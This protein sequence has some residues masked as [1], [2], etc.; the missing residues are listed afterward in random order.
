MSKQT[1]GAIVLAAG[2]GKRMNSKDRN[3]VSLLLGNK[4]I[5]LHAVHLLDKMH[6]QQIVIV[7][8]FAKQTV[9]DIID[10]PKVVFAEQR[11]RLGTGHAVMTAVKKV[12]DTISDVFVLQGDDSF[13][14]T[15]EILSQLANKH[16]AT[17]AAMTCLT[18]QVKNPFGL[19]RVVRE[20]NGKVAA[21]VEEKDA[22]EEQRKINEINPACYIFKVDFLKKYLPKIK[23]SPVTGEYYLTHLIDIAIQ[24]GE[25]VETVQAGFIPWRGINTPEE[26]EEAERLLSKDDLKI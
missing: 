18:I 9:M 24:H 14:Y 1:L 21:I 7:V 13:L 2:K 25:N 22:T 6:L 16:F 12:S 23:K 8:G 11:L 15:E 17:N 3:K 20:E 5:I 26:L 4:P 19:G 10:V